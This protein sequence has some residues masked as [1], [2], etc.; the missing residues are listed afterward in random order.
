MLINKAFADYPFSNIDWEN[1][2]NKFSL[3]KNS[4]LTYLKI[5]ELKSDFYG[6]DCLSLIKI[7]NYKITL[8]NFWVTKLWI[9]KYCW[10]NIWLLWSVKNNYFPELWDQIV[11]KINPENNYISELYLMNWKSINEINDFAKTLNLPYCSW[12]S[13]TEPIAQN[14][15]N[16]FLSWSLTLSFIIIL[17]LVFKLLKI[18]K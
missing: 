6:S 4:C 18:K 16:Y 7:W 8:N 12:N 17:V 1:F 9:N 15:S 2:Q 5:S 10:N 13:I 14:Y 3:S 11:A